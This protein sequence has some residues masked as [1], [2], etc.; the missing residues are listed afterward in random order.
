M[1]TIGDVEY[2]ID[3]FDFDDNDE[4][5]NYRQT[6]M[7]VSEFLEQNILSPFQENVIGYISGYVVRMAE[8]IIK[9]TPCINSL[10]SEYGGAHPTAL[11]L[12][13]KKTRGGLIIPSKDVTDLCIITNTYFK[14]A[15]INLKLK[16]QDE[17]L[18]L[19]ILCDLNI[20]EL[21]PSLHSHQF[22][23]EIDN[24]H[25]YKLTKTIIKCFI[26]IKFSQISKEINDANTTHL[27]QQLS[28]LIIFSHE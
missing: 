5:S 16:N 26:K 6:N 8:K 10:H 1:L 18:A 4:N 2:P 27:R 19:R 12:L 7:L 23:T 24:N 20:G 22:D 13:F 15:N 17:R 14:N 9:C 21:F 28:R 3:M 11:N 25:I